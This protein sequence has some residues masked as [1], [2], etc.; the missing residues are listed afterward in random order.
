MVARR[1]ELETKRLV[2]SDG[3]YCPSLSCGLITLNITSQIYVVGIDGSCRMH[4]GCEE[5]LQCN[6]ERCGKSAVTAPGLRSSRGYE[7]YSLYDVT[8]CS[9]TDAYRRFER[10]VINRLICPYDGSIL[11]TLKL[12]HGMRSFILTQ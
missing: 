9:L 8:R 4:T 2:S 1:K 3:G 10:N 12:H 11:N 7:V 5:A 6:R